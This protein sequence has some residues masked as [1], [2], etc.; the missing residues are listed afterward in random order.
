M[1]SHISLRGRAGMILVPAACVV[2]T[3]VAGCSGAASTVAD[4]A[5]GSPTTI[6]AAPAS[7][8]VST[9]ASTPASAS[10]SSSDAGS[11]G[12]GSSGGSAVVNMKDGQGDSY[13]QTF[14]F[15]SP[16]PESN[17][18]DA[19]SGMQ[20]CELGVAIPARNLVVPVQITTTLTTSVQTQI[21]IQMDV[22]DY[23]QTGFGTAGPNAGIPGDV[24]YQTTAGDQCETNQE[25]AQVTLGQGQSATTQ[26]WI[27]LQDA[28]TPAYPDGDLAQLGENFVYFGDDN[29]VTSAQGAAVCS[30]NSQ[31]Q[32]T[33]SPP[34]LVFVGNAPSGEGCDGQYTAPAN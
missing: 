23:A 24:V 34:Y 18:P 30:G 13:T 32:E 33:Y 8:Q 9:P 25:G 17:V 15:G 26:A 5:V 21:P 20:T 2:L 7:S 4:P 27:V 6:P 31:T 22:T 1:P 11:S 10:A 12:A 19:V 29:T 16:E 3:A 28:I 14:A